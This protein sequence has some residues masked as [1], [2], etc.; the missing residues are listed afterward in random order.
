VPRRPGLDWRPPCLRW[1]WAGL[2]P[3]RTVAPDRGRALDAPGMV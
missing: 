1:R 2:V 3:C